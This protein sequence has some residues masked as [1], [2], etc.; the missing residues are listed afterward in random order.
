MDNRFLPPLCVVSERGPEGAAKLACLDALTGGQSSIIVS[1]GQGVD[2]MILGTFWTSAIAVTVVLLLLATLKRL[3]AIA[4]YD[5][6]Q[7]A[8]G[9]TG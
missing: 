3:H 2:R 1:S 4:R 6:S 7:R 8:L 9:R 5:G